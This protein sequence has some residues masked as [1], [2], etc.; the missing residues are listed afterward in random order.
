MTTPDKPFTPRG[1]CHAWTAVVLVAIVGTPNYADLR[2]MPLGRA[3]LIVPVAR[4]LAIFCYV[5]A[6]QRFT[7]EIYEGPDAPV[8]QNS[9]RIR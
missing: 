4:V 8:A 6:S 7:R 3:L 2:D 9:K 5:A 1:S